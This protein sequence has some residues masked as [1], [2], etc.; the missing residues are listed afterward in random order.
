MKASAET[1][2]LSRLI[3]LEI[4]KFGASPIPVEELTQ[5]VI[6]AVSQDPALIERC[7]HFYLRAKVNGK[8]RSRRG[9]GRVTV[10][11]DPTQ[12]TG[13]WVNL[14]VGEASK[15]QKLHK[16]E[17]YQAVI[18]GALGE[19]DRLNPNSEEFGEI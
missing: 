4:E 15:E 5:R 9:S 10:Q 3:Q 2:F 13:P 19:I 6:D 7:V 11:I 8:L 16:I 17:K 14:K 18:K 1:K 12:K